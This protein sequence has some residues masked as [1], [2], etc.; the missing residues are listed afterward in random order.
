M[1]AAVAAPTL[2]LDAHRRT[3]A[4]L[5]RARRPAF[6]ATGLVA[7]LPISMVGLG[8]R[9]AGRRTSPAPTAYA[10]AVAGGVHGRQRRV[11]RS[12]RAALARPAR[13]RAGCCRARILAFGV[14]AWSLLVVAVQARL[15]DA[16]AYALAA[17]AGACLPPIGACVRA[18]WS[19]VLDRA[20]PRCRRRTRSRRCVDEAVFI[21]GPILVT[22]AGHRLAPGRRPR[23]RGG[24]RRRRHALRSPPSAPPSRPAH[25]RT[26]PARRPR[27]ADAVAD[28]GARWRS[29]ALAL[30]VAVR[31]GRGDHRRVRRGARRQAGVRRAA[32]AV[33]A[34]Q[35]ARRRRSRARSTGRAGRRPG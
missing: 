16:G 11:R 32:G 4:I 35:P 22:A 24:R 14:G 28:R 17:V 10:G 25:P 1:D 13:A 33:G 8:H 27:A 21:I 26:G 20:A 23:G 15:A 19:H 9:A 30:G 31:R 6:S 3:A 18:R 34:R 12:S 29:C 7:R 5:A 2:W